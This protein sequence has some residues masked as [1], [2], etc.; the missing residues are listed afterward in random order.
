MAKYLVFTAAIEAHYTW[1]AVIGILT[2][3]LQTA[4]IFRIINIMFGKQPKNNN[5]IT[6]TMNKKIYIPIFIMVAAIFILGLFPDIVLQLIQPV[7][8]QLPFLP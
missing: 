5:P 4:Y 2:S 7:I 8:N 3:I 6:F 1:L